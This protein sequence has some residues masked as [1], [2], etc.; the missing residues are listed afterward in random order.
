MSF[1]DRYHH[2]PMVKVYR[3]KAAKQASQVN[4]KPQNKYNHSK[5]GVVHSHG[6]SDSVGGYQY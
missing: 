4:N 6:S 5:P 2:D 3:F 1:P